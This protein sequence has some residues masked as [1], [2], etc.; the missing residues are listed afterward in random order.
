[1]KEKNLTIERCHCGKF[2]IIDTTN[3]DWWGNH[4]I[5]QGSIIG[6]QIKVA[7]TI[8]RPCPDCQFKSDR[9]VNP[10]WVES[11]KEV[12]CPSIFIG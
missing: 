8:V 1:M 5:P 2:R 12:I 3:Y 6:R 7:T 4:H 9:P 10:M 11:R